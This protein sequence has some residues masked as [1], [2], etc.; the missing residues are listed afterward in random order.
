MSKTLDYVD[1]V[2]GRFSCHFLG[3]DLINGRNLNQH[4]VWHVQHYVL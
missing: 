4:V 3:K 2:D 1:T